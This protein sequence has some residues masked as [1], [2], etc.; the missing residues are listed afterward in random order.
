MIFIFLKF[1]FNLNSLKRSVFEKVFKIFTHFD[2]I[3]INAISYFRQIR[4]SN[5]VIDVIIMKNINKVFNSKK[6]VDSTTILP[7]NLQKFQNVFSQLL[8][9]NL[10]KHRFYDHVIFLLKE[11]TSSFEIFYEMFR[12]E[13]FCCRKY[14]DNMFKKNFIRL[15]HFSAASSILFIKKSKNKLRFCVDYRNLNVIII[16]N[17]YSIFLIRETL[18]RL[19]KVKIYIKVNI[20]VVYNVLRM[21]FKE[22]WKT[23]FQTRYKFYEYF[24]MFFNLI[25]ALLS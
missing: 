17:Q 5:H 1:E 22:K 3:M 11:K 2:I 13:L 19:I 9:N 21:T 18:H 15:N 7:L 20:I 4:K 14:L 24:V 8:I 12:D 23:V 6:K 25:N 16:K 10:S